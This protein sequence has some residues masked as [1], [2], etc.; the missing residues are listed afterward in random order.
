MTYSSLRS[1]YHKLSARGSL[2]ICLVQRDSYILTL[3]FLANNPLGLLLISLLLK[4]RFSSPICRES[5]L[6]VYGSFHGC[7]DFLVV[8]HVIFVS[9][10]AFFIGFSCAPCSF[11]SEVFGLGFVGGD[12]G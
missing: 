11:H 12:H 7:V 6:R 8:A 1:L 3:G 10:Q 5:D 9:F 4:R 2:V